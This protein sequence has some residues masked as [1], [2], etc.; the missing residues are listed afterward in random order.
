MKNYQF[1]EATDLNGTYRARS[2][3]AKAQSPA[4]GREQDSFD[5]FK[6]VNGVADFPSGRRHAAR[7]AV[8]NQTDAIRPDQNGRLGRSGI[9]NRTQRQLQRL[10]I[11]IEK[12][13]R[14]ATQPTLRN[15]SKAVQHG[16]AP[17]PRIALDRTDGV[18]GKDEH[19]IRARELPITLDRRMRKRRLQGLVEEAPALRRLVA[20]DRQKEPQLD[21]RSAIPGSIRPSTRMR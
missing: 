15:M 7:G 18:W 16:S 21:R 10:K 12:Y 19:V 1:S 2:V 9:D 5:R 3:R 20:L 13:A 4:E 14:R 17:E 8:D 11:A 6:H